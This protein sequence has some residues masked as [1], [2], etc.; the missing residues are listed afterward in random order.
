VVATRTL[1]GVQFP[2]SKVLPL[3]STNPASLAV[4]SA[5]SLS[6]AGRKPRDSRTLRRY[7]AAVLL[8]VSALTVAVNRVVAAPGLLEDDG[9]AILREAAA[10]S[11]P[12]A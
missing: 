12:C 5:G 6:D 11:S 3:M 9:I 4:T 10:R 7:G 8:V 2:V 1:G